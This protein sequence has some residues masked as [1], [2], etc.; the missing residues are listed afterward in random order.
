MITTESFKDLKKAL[1]TV[2]RE[3][4]AVCEIVCSSLQ[5]LI[6]QTK[7]TIEGK[8]DLHGSDTSTSRQRDMISYSL[9][10]AA[11]HGDFLRWSVVEEWEVCGQSNDFGQMRTTELESCFPK[12]DYIICF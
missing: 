10:V 11:E 7:G 2:L 9:Q 1:C 6:Q 4:P 8:I 12:S 5:I 3:G